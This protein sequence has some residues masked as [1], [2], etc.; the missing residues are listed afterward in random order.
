VQDDVENVVP[1]W[2]GSH[3]SQLDASLFSFEAPHESQTW[4]QI[5]GILNDGPIPTMYSWNGVGL[6]MEWSVCMP[7]GK[8]VLYVAFSSEFFTGLTQ[9]TH[10]VI[11]HMQK[12]ESIEEL[13]VIHINNKELAPI[14]IRTDGKTTYYKVSILPVPK[15]GLNHLTA[16]F[17]VARRFHKQCSTHYDYIIADTPWGGI[18]ALLLKLF[19]RSK[20][21][22][23]EDMDYFPGFYTK[24]RFRR[25]IMKLYEFIIMRRSRL[26]ITVGELLKEERQRVRKKDIHVKVNGVRYELFNRAVKNVPHPPTLIYMG[27]LDD[28]S[29]VDLPI[30]CM[31][32]LLRSFP[33]LKL[34]IVGHGVGQ[35]K[36]K[37]LAE[38]LGVQDYVEFAGLKAYE[39]LPAELSRADIG[40]ATFRKIPLMKYAFTLKVVE[41][42]A[43]GL[44]VIASAIGETERYIRRHDTGILIDGDEQSFVDAVRR[45]LS[46]RTLYERLSANGIRSAEQYDWERILNERQEIID[47]VLDAQRR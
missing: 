26:V 39:E 9:R 34:L 20:T 11:R 15:W 45:L 6:L 7:M 40:L 27:Y 4:E 23:Y 5:R 33:D 31:P 41:Y 3:A 30:R 17:R 24:S 47:R 46:D 43:A 44:P 36:L 2:I 8:R 18:I 29:G 35:K 21:V 32:E 25:T 42:G 22:I 1:E 10:H 14:E 16:P 13:H 28:W 37:E 12:N 19:G 38:S